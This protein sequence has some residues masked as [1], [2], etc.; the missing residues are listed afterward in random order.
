V[1][2]NVFCVLLGVLCCQDNKSALSTLG[3][4]YITEQVEVVSLHELIIIRGVVS[5]GKAF[6]IADCLK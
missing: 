3:L 5:V 2:L 6:L 1:Q 4:V